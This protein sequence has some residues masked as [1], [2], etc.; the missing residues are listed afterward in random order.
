MM[1][2]ALAEDSLS[3]RQRCDEII[4]ELGKLSDKMRSFMQVC[5]D[6]V[7]AIVCVWGG[8]GPGESSSVC[9][10]RSS[11]STSWAG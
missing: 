8:G 5:V 11:S 1:A 6:T 4:D 9:L 10:L 7:I 3:K 2:L